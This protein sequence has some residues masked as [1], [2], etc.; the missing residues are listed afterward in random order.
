MDHFWFWTGCN[1]WYV[2]HWWRVLR[3]E[4]VIL[5]GWKVFLIRPKLTWT[6]NQTSSSWRSI[7]HPVCSSYLGLT[8]SMHLIQQLLFDMEIQDQNLLNTWGELGLEVWPKG[9]K[10][11]W[12]ITY[13]VYMPEYLMVWKYPSPTLRQRRFSD[14][15]YNKVDAEKPSMT[16]CLERISLIDDSSIKPD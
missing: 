16:S 8:L 9:S 3:E 5:I 7:W 6:M 11:G 1:K 4:V 12:T 10:L 14:S 13:G 2:N 15:T